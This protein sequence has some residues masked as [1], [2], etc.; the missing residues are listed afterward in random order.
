[1]K[2]LI[3]GSNLENY[4]AKVHEACKQGL[5]ALFDARCYGEGYPFYDPQI[6]SFVEMKEIMFGKEDIDLI[7]LT[8]CWDSSDLGKGLKY[9]DLDKLNCKKAIRL[10]DFWKEADCQKGLYN[11]FIIK[12]HIDYILPYFRAP[13][14]L[15]KDL[16]IF[17]RLVWYP[18]CFDPLIFNDWGYEK[19]WDVGNLN[20]GSLN[21]NNFYPERYSIH[22]KLLEMKDIKYFYAKHPG[23][24]FLPADTPLIGKRFSEAINRCKIFVTTGNLQY[25]NFAPKY[26]EAMASRACLFA[27]EPMDAEL[28]G[29]VDGYNYVKIDESNVQSKVEYYLSHEE[30]RAKIATEGYKLVFEKYSC[31]AQANYVINQELLEKI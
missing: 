20:A 18:P 26:V 14:Y 30:E 31:Y 8:G 3:E 6:T 24:G 27:N 5:R 25:R 13:F 9:Q 7:L 4:Y 22:Q 16:E 12:N 29:L 15:W 17:D 10:Y 23:T 2:I 1:M 19:I 21:R 28:I 11:H